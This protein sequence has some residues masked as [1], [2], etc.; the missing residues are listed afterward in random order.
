MLGC[1]R[2]KGLPDDL[3]ERHPALPRQ[4][5]QSL[6]RLL[7][8]HDGCAPHVIIMTVLTYGFPRLVQVGSKHRGHGRNSR[9]LARL[10]V[11][12]TGTSSAGPLGGLAPAGIGL[13]W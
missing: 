1:L 5:L 10:I 3:A 12:L 6:Q 11:F 4:E 9:Y 13:P 2:L 7:V 8:G